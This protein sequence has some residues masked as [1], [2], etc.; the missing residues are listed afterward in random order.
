MKSSNY[1]LPLY[2][3]RISTN[4]CDKISGDFH[5]TT[6]IP[7]IDPCPTDM[8]ISELTFSDSTSLKQRLETMEA[9]IINDGCSINTDIANQS[10][11]QALTTDDL[12]L[13][14]LLKSKSINDLLSNLNIDVVAP[15]TAKLSDEK[16]PTNVNE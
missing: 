9:G 12:R 3:S 16:Q 7:T 6:G 2:H 5:F 8:T 15:D 11:V 4:D 1:Y 13:D 10:S 14:S